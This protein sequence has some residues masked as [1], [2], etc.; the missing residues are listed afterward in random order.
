MNSNAL[1]F[2]QFLGLISFA[3]GIL[4]FYQ[5]SDKRLKITMVVLNINYM[6][7]FLLLGA[8]VSVL[9]SFLAAFRTGLSIYISSKIIA[10]I[11]VGIGII[12][13][14][15]LAT[16][17]WDLFP[18]MGTCIGTL[19]LFLLKGIKMRLCLLL[20]STCWLINNILVGSIGGTLL[21]SCVIVINLFTIY[22]LYHIENKKPHFRQL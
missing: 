1:L 10:F 16:S 17:L 15:W 22:R 21:E 5:K 8:P 14:I 13:G 11:F 2:A 6:V 18:I 9:S 19:S 3:L 7:H 20:G 12:F 4:A